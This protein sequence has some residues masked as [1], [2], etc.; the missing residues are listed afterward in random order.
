MEAEAVDEAGLTG[1]AAAG[2]KAVD[3]DDDDPPLVAITSPIDGD[4]ITS[5]TIFYGTIDDDGLESY[6]LEYSRV[7]Q[8][9]WTTITSGDSPV[10]DAEIGT[11]D[12]TTLAN[13]LYTVRLSAEDFNGNYKQVQATCLVSGY[14]KPGQNQLAFTDLQ[15]PVLG[16]QHHRGPGVQQL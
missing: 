12:P 1:T 11:F 5:P 6:T 4:E 9:E 7:D 13:G 14:L 16:H 15:I 2:F 3:P 8:N 10:H